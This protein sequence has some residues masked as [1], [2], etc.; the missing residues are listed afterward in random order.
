MLQTLLPV[1]SHLDVTLKISPSKNAGELHMFLQFNLRT[2]K[3]D[4]NVSPLEFEG[5]PEEIERMMQQDLQQFLNTHQTNVE[6][7][8]SLAKALEDAEKDLTAKAKK[9]TKKTT[10]KVEGKS[11]AKS[12]SKPD[13]F[14][15]ATEPEKPEKKSEP[16]PPPVEEKVETKPIEAKSESKTTT[17]GTLILTEEEQE[18][19]EEA[20]ASPDELPLMDPDDVFEPMTAPPPPKT[21]EEIAELPTIRERIKERA[22]TAPIPV[23]GG[24][25]YP[26]PQ[27]S[28]ADLANATKE[29]TVETEWVKLREKAKKQGLTLTGINKD[30]QTVESIHKLFKLIDN[31]GK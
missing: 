29:L 16:K 8:N 18:L 10:A 9:T 30:E 1:V 15:Q 19:L 3:T 7:I 21:P 24:S 14:A 13:L 17:Q 2:S 22:K 6:R 11:E 28:L 27:V 23:P 4:F 20:Y 26:Q 31:Y 12:E 25:V 5:T